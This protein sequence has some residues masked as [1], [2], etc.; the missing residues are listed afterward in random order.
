MPKQA[1]NGNC[2]PTKKMG[3]YECYR[4]FVVKG[5]IILLYPSENLKNPNLFQYR[6][7]FSAQKALGT[8]VSNSPYIAVN[9]TINKVTVSFNG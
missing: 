2:S 6:N 4:Q 8:Y 5:G 7:G 3:N 1:H 9:S